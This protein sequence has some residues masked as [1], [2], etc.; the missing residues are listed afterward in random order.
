MRLTTVTFAFL[1]F[2]T[3]FAT[4]VFSP[5][6]NVVELSKRMPPK[7]SSDVSPSPNRGRSRK[8]TGGRSAKAQGKQKATG[9][10][11]DGGDDGGEDDN[12]RPGSKRKASGPSGSRKRSKKNDKNCVNGLVNQA[13]FM[14]ALQNIDQKPLSRGSHGLAVFPIKTLVNGCDAVVKIIDLVR[15]D[16]DQKA[17]I[18]KE[19]AG[20]LQAEQLLGWGTR[21]KPKLNYILMKHMGG[22]LKDT[23]LHPIE[24]GPLIEEMKNAALERY[25]T[26][27]GLKQLDRTGNGN[28]LWEPLDEANTDKKARYIVNVI[29]WED[30]ETVGPKAGVK[31]KPPTAFVV[32]NDKT[33]YGPTS[34]PESSEKSDE[35]NKGEESVKIYHNPNP[36]GSTRSSSRIKAL[37]EKDASTSGQN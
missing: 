15:F 35:E 34:S 4:P 6:G 32:P 26:Q 11:D 16:D 22:Q 7:A 21:A 19:V 27:F 23:N 28:Y 10:G 25:E 9:G 17:N 12:S 31:L 33:I 24:D 8:K 36:S 37:A 13:D 29:D 30:Y 20:L 1:F 5:R 18:P 14:T 3:V 2:G